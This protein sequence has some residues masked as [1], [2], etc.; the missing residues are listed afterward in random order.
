MNEGQITSSPAPIPIASSES[1]RASVPLATPIVCGNA[2]IRSGLL[3]E[4]L[5]LGPEDESTRLEHLGET[6]LELGDQRRV[7]RLDV[8][9]RNHDQRVYRA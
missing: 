9:K 7:L 1:T 4:G 8:D 2:E 6:V 5:D 3:L